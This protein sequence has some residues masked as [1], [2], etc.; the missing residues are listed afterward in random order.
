MRVLPKELLSIILHLTTCAGSSAWTLS[1]VCRAWRR[2]VLAEPNKF[3]PNPTYIG[4]LNSAQFALEL[5]VWS[6]CPG[7]PGL[8]I[9]WAP[10]AHATTDSP[11][12]SCAAQ[13][14]L[15]LARFLSALIAAT[16]AAIQPQRTQVLPPPLAQLLTE[17][18][19]LSGL[20]QLHLMM[21]GQDLP[22]RLD[23]PR[24]ESLTIHHC[25]IRDFDGIVAPRLRHLSL[26]DVR[27]PI[28]A[29]IRRVML[30]LVELSV[31]MPS[32]ADR[33]PRPNF[34]PVTC[35]NLTSFTVRVPPG[36]RIA[37]ALSFVAH[38]AQVTVETAF[39]FKTT[40]GSR[41]L[42]D[43]PEITDLTV[44][45]TSW[46]AEDRS[47]GIRRTIQTYWPFAMM[48][49]TFC[50]QDVRIDALRYL[51]TDEIW[52]LKTHQFLVARRP[53]SLTTIVIKL[54]HRA[55]LAKNLAWHEPTSHCDFES[56]RLPK[57]AT[58]RFLA[59]DAE[60]LPLELFRQSLYDDDLGCLPDAPP[61]VIA[62]RPYL[63][64]TRIMM[65]LLSVCR[66][67]SDGSLADF[68]K[69][70]L[71]CDDAAFHALLPIVDIALDLADDVRRGPFS[72]K[73]ADGGCRISSTS[74]L[75]SVSRCNKCYIGRGPRAA[76][77]S[78]RDRTVPNCARPRDNESHRRLHRHLRT[79]R[80]MLG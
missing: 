66:S 76:T 16:G 74:M 47:R 73:V 46:S 10:S 53:A 44:L 23:C 69:I 3:F 26:T 63:P 52:W 71:E 42:S 17:V 67:G 45:H 80:R 36:Q 7:R 35:P 21:Q 25:L 1:H 48:P 75:I 22:I 77:Q 72:S 12:N 78:N 28:H 13:E 54:N 58:L 5:D 8:Q 30:S 19:P 39:N 33:E 59:H 65:R 38:P 9:A 32:P 11:C 51:C 43:I 49:E 4:C 68:T 20:T 6:R 31:H 60:P 55:S 2:T 79:C 61:A 56:E 40:T 14:P 37:Y 62:I 27:G 29:L 15:S 18:G 41:I 50:P 57:L 24:L 70:A 34:P 64:Y